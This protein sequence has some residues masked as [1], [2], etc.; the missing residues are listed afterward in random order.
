MSLSS[1]ERRSILSIAALFLVRMSGLFMTLPVFA[2]YAPSLKGASAALIGLAVGAHG[3]TQALLQIPFGVWSDRWGRKQVILIG[4]S[5]FVAG[6]LIAAMSDSIYGVIAGRFLQGAGAISSVMMA[7]L[8]DLTRDEHRTQAMAVV[9]GSIGLSFAASI[10]AGPIVAAL[11]GLEG[12]F[13]LTL[14]LGLAS[15][16][17]MLWVIPEPEARTHLREHGAVLSQVS[18]VLLDGALLR[19]NFGVFVLHLTMMASFVALPTM[20]VSD[21]QLP[22]EHHWHLYLPVVLLS[23]VA[24]VPIVIIAEKKQRMKEAFL[25]ATLVLGLSLFAMP[26]AMSGWW[27]M[28]AALFG[29]FWAFNLLEA[30]MPSWVSKVAPAGSRGTAMGVYSSCQFMGVFV[31]GVSGGWLSTHWSGSLLLWV[32]AAVVVV[33]ALVALTMIPPKHLSN[34]VVPI[35]PHQLLAVDLV[36]RISNVMGVEDVV[37]VEEEG[38]AYLKIDKAVFDANKL[39]AALA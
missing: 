12:V 32:M 19:L 2:L 13:W 34:H 28:F 27:L 30:T 6:S 7:L 38:M 39:T 37:V 22:K 21:L 20:L 16:A 17:I 25:L 24:I 5:I 35:P 9:G 10:V 15:L 36:R 8:A 23:F 18:N 11:A 33:W 1:L 14:A 29:Y 4:L 31:G 3:L 26:F